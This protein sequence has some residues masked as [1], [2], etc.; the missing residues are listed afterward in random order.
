[1]WFCFVVFVFSKFTLLTSINFI[2]C[3]GEVQ[4]ER[5][6]ERER[7]TFL[8]M[9]LKLLPDANKWYPWGTA[10]ATAQVLPPPDPARQRDV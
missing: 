4:R 3:V 1:M 9:Q 7:E 2:V 6:R 5:E 10:L 8:S